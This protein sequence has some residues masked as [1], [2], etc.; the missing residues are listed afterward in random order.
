MINTQPQVLLL[1]WN[2][3]HQWITTLESLY[4]SCLQ[5]ARSTIVV[6]FTQVILLV[7]CTRNIF[8]TQFQY[9]NRSL[10]TNLSESNTSNHLVPTNYN[11]TSV[12]FMVPVCAN[13]PFISCLSI[14]ESAIQV[15][16][17]LFSRTQNDSHGHIPKSGRYV[18]AVIE[19]HAQSR[20][21]FHLYQTD[22]QISSPSCLQCMLQFALSPQPRAS[23]SFWIDHCVRILPLY[24]S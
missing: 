10:S 2:I 8:Q 22:L 21:H 16:K 18:Q 4:R 17:S 13:R 5:T 14:P 19:W 6:R 9:Q 23:F 1:H 20:S 11:E 15:Y 3:Q 24:V 7:S 12:R